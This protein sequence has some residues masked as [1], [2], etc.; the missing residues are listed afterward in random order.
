MIIFG[1]SLFLNKCVFQ[2]W[3]HNLSNQIAKEVG[4]APSFMNIFREDPLLAFRVYLGPNLPVHNRLFGP[5][6]HPN[7]W[8]LSHQIYKRVAKETKRDTVKT[9]VK[10]LSTIVLIIILI[11]LF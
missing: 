8:K 10:I 11:I 2:V 4:F 9:L 1:L 5:G 6:S 7:A 3:S